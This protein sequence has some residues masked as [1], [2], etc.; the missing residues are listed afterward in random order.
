MGTS[1]DGPVDSLDVTS[2]LHPARQIF[3]LATLVDTAQHMSKGSVCKAKRQSSRL[4][5][6][7]FQP[8]STPWLVTRANGRDEV[9]SGWSS[10]IFQFLPP[11]KK[12]ADEGK[13]SHPTPSSLA[14]VPTP[15]GS[16]AS[17]NNQHSFPP[18]LFQNSTH[19][20]HH[21][22]Y[23]VTIH[24]N[25]HPSITQPYHHKPLHQPNAVGGKSPISRNR[26]P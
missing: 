22:A 14:I 25:K 1:F 15:F 11:S 10:S 5:Q 7:K 2:T 3:H 16:E 24:I 26:I 12:T 9:I 18:P 4:S 6:L 23:G 19:F 20:C 8:T 21:N 13:D 17:R